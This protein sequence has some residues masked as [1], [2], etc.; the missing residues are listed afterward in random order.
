MKWMYY[1]TIV[2]LVFLASC[3]DLRNNPPV[4][5]SIILD[6]PENFTPGSD[7]RISAIVTDREGDQLE[8]YWQSEGG[9]ISEPGQISANWELSTEAEPLSYETI[10]LSVSDGRELSTRSRTIQVS[11]GLIMKGYTCFAGTTIPVQGV[12]VTIGKFSTVSDENGYYMIRNLKEGY[13]QIVAA[14]DGFDRYESTEYVDH[15]KSTFHIPMT[16]PTETMNVSGYV[17]TVDHLAFEG[18]KV[19]LLNPDHTESELAGYTDQHGHYEIKRVPLGNRKMMIWN[20]KPGS[21]F[22]NDSIVYGFEMQEPEESYDARIK[23]KRAIMDDSF[24]SEMDEWDYKGSTSEGFYVLQRGDEL[25][26]KQPF[27]IPRD[28]EDAML[29]INSFVVGGCDLV[30]RLPSHRVWIAN[31]RDENMGGISWGG[32]GNNFKAE[33]SWYPS[34]SPTYM[35]IYGREIKLYLEIFGEANCIPDPLWRIYHIEFSYYY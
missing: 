6:P 15:P 29:Y 13:E 25:M 31:S 23:I 28:A 19:V 5:E 21:V 1:M 35:N 12:E 2:V 3:S 8:Y 11:E 14:R 34:E 22:L 7:I 27:T 17:R 4:I 10:T 26:M 33:V 9:I 16:S 32:D 24:M 18:L 30:G 20:E